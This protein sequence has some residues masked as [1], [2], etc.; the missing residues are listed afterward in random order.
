MMAGKVGEAKIPWSDTAV[1]VLLDHPDGRGIVAEGTLRQM[2][3]RIATRPTA[4][5]HRF[6][7]S[8]P[9]RGVAPF[10]FESAEFNELILAMPT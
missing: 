2:V 7:I 5:W 9:D 1:L 10:A 3:N 6:S 8:L 4:E